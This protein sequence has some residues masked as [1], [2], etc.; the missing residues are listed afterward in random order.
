MMDRR[1]VEGELMGLPFTWL[2]KSWLTILC[3]GFCGQRQKRLT[4]ETEHQRQ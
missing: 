3:N 4:W 1:E 2:C